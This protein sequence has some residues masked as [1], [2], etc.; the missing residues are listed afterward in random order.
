MARKEGV[1]YVYIGNVPGH[2]YEHTYCPECGEVLI[3]RYSMYLV[4]NR[5]ENG[6]CWKCGKEIYGVW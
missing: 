4:E 6:K 1:E 5:I 2:K 3:K